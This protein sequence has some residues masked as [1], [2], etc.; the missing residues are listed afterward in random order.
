MKTMNADERGQSSVEEMPIT[1]ETAN[2]KIN[3]QRTSGALLMLCRAFYEKPE[4]EEA[5][6]EW[7]AQRKGEKAG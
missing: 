4:N 6:R 7:K 3:Y 1:L 2:T 5:F